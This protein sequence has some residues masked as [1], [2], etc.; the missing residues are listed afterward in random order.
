MIEYLNGQI[1]ELN[2][3]H[4]VIDVN[5]IG[6]FVHISLN[7]YSALSGHKTTKLL[8]HEIIREDL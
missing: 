7:T 4:V 1:V 6:Y 3:A 5:G 2:P 8:I